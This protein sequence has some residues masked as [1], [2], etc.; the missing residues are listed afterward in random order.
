MT[1]GQEQALEQLHE[2][3]K[4]GAG[5]LEVVELTPSEATANLVRVDLSLRTGHLARVENGLP[6]RERERFLIDIPPDF[7]FEHP[8]VETRHSRFAG[9]PHVQFGRHL[10]LYQAPG[11]EWNPS[12]G[13]FGFLVRLEEWLAQGAANQLD[14][15][16]GA[17]HP[18]AVYPTHSQLVIPRADAPAVGLGHWLGLARLSVV[19]DRRLDIVG[20]LPAVGQEVVPPVGAA[21]LL[22]STMPWEF[23]RS[24]KE[25]VAHLEARGVERNS[26]LLAF[27]VAVIRNPED[28]PLY[29]VIGAPMRGIRGGELRQHLSVWFIEP[30]MANA[31]RLALEKYSRHERLQEIGAEVE[32]IIWEWAD[33]VKVSWCNVREDR[34]EIVTR[35]DHSSPM[36]FFR[37]KT[38]ALW[39]CG[40]LGS[41]V[42]E[43]LVRAGV[44]K[45]VL[46]DSGVVG[47][48]L[49]V[50]QQFD[51]AD[52][53]KSKAGS[54]ALRL[55]RIRGELE[56]EA[57]LDDLVTGLLSAENWDDD[58][59]VII[60]STG[61]Q[62]VLKKLEGRWAAASVRKPVVASLVVGPDAERA[63]AVV[64]RAG[65]HSG[66]PLD[67]ARRA[68]LAACADE[69]LL[70]FRQ[71]FWPDNLKAKGLFQP[72]PGC[73]APTFVG[74][75]ADLAELAGAMTNL[76]AR[77][78][79]STD[80]AH[81]HFILRHDLDVD[82]GER[83]SAHFAWTAE[84]T[85]RD[86]LRGY[87]V[88]ISDSAWASILA[89]IEEDRRR[90]GPLV[91]T[92]G[93]LLGERDD[94]SRVVWVTV[95]TDPPP[96]SRATRAG[97]V[98]GT[99]GCHEM[100]ARRGAETL[101][102]VRFVGMWHTHPG[103]P[104]EPSSIDLEGMARLVSSL[105]P[106]IAQ[107]LLVIVGQT[108]ASPVPAAYLF[109]RDDFWGMLS[110]SNVTRRATRRSW[111]WL[112]QALRALLSRQR[113]QRKQA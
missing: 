110:A 26:L 21:V 2:V 49:L 66:G 25:L 44:R 69:T 57:A 19:S 30:N 51:D 103:A 83:V 62:S 79:S 24:V 84:R 48:G 91:E 104:P 34:P 23:P 101:N 42:A 94:A 37:N 6:L 108:P 95:A 88:H 112:M 11:V 109:K 78:A 60:E 29:V 111:A 28:A 5:D 64:A 85:V 52:I 31:L 54:L 47:P 65:Q 32:A 76:V 4:F 89:V 9:F 39:G 53:G 20:W 97:F 75:S 86:S 17:L 59:D 14:P 13:F 73:S 41:H 106:P 80:S 27:Q 63:L 70:R 12:D 10:C 58:A 18:P 3:A 1:E 100:D 99:Q 68:K 22:A 81:A 50:R 15:V 113:S 82:P 35:R 102:G 61:S 98:C 46:R 36:A 38:V 33:L 96:D 74:S 55:K 7:P 77:D 93:L 40:A 71:E 67:V 107:A 90:K 45:L 16:G 56:V 8:I 72:E 43:L 92:G 87:H 105:D